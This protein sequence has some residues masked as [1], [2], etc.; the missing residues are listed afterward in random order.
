M[1]WKR[2]ASSAVPVGLDESDAREH[3]RQITLDAVCRLP[4]ICGGKPL[5]GGRRTA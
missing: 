4:H 1:I 3:E 5:P 2:A